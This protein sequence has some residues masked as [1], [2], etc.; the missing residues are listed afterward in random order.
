M[1]DNEKEDY[2]KFSDYTFGNKACHR[3]HLEKS[4][5]ISNYY[6]DEAL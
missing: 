5:I 1:S 3:P 2:E 6:D 4:S